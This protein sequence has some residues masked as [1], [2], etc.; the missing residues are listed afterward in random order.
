MATLKMERTPLQRAKGSVRN[1]TQTFLKFKHKEPVFDP[2]DRYVPNEM[3]IKSPFVD[4][5]L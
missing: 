4:S 2:R 3:F 1:H 5:D